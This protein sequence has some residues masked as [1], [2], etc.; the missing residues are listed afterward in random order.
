M[1]Q[2]QV[3]LRYLGRKLRKSK[4]KIPDHLKNKKKSASFELLLLWCKG[5]WIVTGGFGNEVV[6]F[7]KYNCPENPSCCSKNPLLSK[8]YFEHLG[9][10]LTSAQNI[11]LF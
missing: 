2:L 11:F 9:I 8:E 4:A 6:I 3:Y 5:K 7:I 1:G 10:F